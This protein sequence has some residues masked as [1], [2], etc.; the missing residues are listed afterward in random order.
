MEQREP[1]RGNN[2]RF[3]L[4]DDPHFSWKKSRAIMRDSSIN[5]QCCAND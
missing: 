1:I 3:L 2:S 4:Y 5:L